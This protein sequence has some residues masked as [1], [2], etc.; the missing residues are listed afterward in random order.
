L[1]RKVYWRPSDPRSATFRGRCFDEMMS[2]EGQK[3]MM[4]T[5][6]ACAEYVPGEEGEG[7]FRQGATSGTRAHVALTR[8]AE[9]EVVGSEEGGRR[10]LQL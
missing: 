5:R 4:R 1:R 2:T 10:Q 7:F 8:N 6:G 9:L 3:D